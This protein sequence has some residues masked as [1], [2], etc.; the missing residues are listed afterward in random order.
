M[1]RDIQLQEV[2]N[3][4]VDP[5][6]A[7]RKERGYLMAR[8]IQLQEVTNDCVDPNDA[9]QMRLRAEFYVRKSLLAN[10]STFQKFLG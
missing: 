6:D 1:A 7:N 9:C 4:C 2:T 10:E 5:N 8:D 3:D